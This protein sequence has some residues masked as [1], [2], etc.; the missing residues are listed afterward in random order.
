MCRSVPQMDAILTLTSTSVRPNCGLGTSRISMPGADVGLTT[1]NMVFDIRLA[2]GFGS[3][4]SL[5]AGEKMETLA[6]RQ[7]SVNEKRWATSQVYHA[8]GRA[9]SAPG[10]QSPTLS[11][12][13]GE[14]GTRRMLGC[15]TPATRLNLLLRVQERTCASMEC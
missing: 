9:I 4:P 15:A 14:R 10:V 11:P 5:T 13:A 6:L 7:P 3:H 1:A 2:L 8:E 12:K